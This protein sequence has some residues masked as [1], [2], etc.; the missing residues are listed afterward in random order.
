[1]CVCVFYESFGP[2]AIV[3]RR[4]RPPGGGVMG[5]PR[6]PRSRF[7]VEIGRDLSTLD[8]IENMV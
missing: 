6:P 7:G 2:A 1:V 5:P 3:E 8:Q 4:V